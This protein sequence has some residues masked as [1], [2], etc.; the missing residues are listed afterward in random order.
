MTSFYRIDPATG[1]EYVGVQQKGAALLRDPLINKGSA[2]T[3]AERE[4]LDLVGLLPPAVSSMQQQLDR[5][6]EHFRAQRDDLSRYVNLASLHDRNETLFFRLLQEHLEEMMPVVYTPV[7]GLACQHYSHIYRQGRGLH[8]S[9][10]QRGRIEAVLRQVPHP[11]SVIVVTDGERILGLGDQGVGGMGIPIGKASLYTLCGGI[12]PHRTLPVMLDVGTDNEERL[13]DPLYLGLR[14]ERIR[15]EA[16]QAFIDEF[17]AGVARVWPHALLQW[18]DLLKG[19]AL[20]QLHRFRDRVCSFND[21]IQGTAAVCVAGIHGGLRV[22][23]QAARDQRIVLAGAGAA[24]QG[25]ADLVVADLV[26]DG[27]SPEAARRRIWMVDRQGLVVD[28]RAGLE[29]FKALYARPAAEVGGYEH[30]DRTHLDLEATVANAR[31]TILIGISGQPGLFS[32]PVIERMA[33]FTERPLVFPLSNP[34]S[35]SECHP[36]DAL[37]WSDGRAV[38]ATGS[39]FP[40]VDHAGKTI[41]IGQ[42]N[43]SFIFP[44]VGLGVMLGRVRRVSDGLFLAGARA[45]AATVTKAELE[46]GSIFPSVTRIRE[47]A[48]AVACAVIRR[49]VADGE[50]NERLL[51]GLE[52]TVHRAM[53]RPEYRPVRFSE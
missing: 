18:E 22:S 6:Y 34:T 44:G 20:T 47:C 5:T 19:N 3:A 28:D 2:F 26:E 4:A 33:T 31:P 25:I 45:L 30:A 21:D 8:I 1:E 14:H 27:L 13:A 24:A 35:N 37:R 15:G 16:Y 46:S 52:G 41:R 40:P 23:G 38:V 42:G 32:R 12:Q 9:Y 10:D 11:P 43:N 29:S 7:V 36:R 51:D 49:A 53:W 48:R 17:V 50:A 39:P